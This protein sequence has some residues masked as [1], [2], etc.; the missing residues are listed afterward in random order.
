MPVTERSDGESALAARPAS[1]R[2]EEILSAAPGDRASRGGLGTK[3]AL[4]KKRKLRGKG[5]GVLRQLG[6][7]KRR[8]KG[9]TH[10]LP[11]SLG[12]EVT[13]M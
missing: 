3:L 1:L 9:T 6:V 5:I 13:S 2:G 4:K 10:M 7:D 12:S 11:R 8:E